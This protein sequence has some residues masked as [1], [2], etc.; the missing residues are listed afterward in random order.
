M[1]RASAVCE[2]AGFPAVSLIC[3]GF[4]RQASATSVGLGMPNL[5][6][7]MVPGHIDV[8]SEA[9]LRK[10]ILG[11][12]TDLVIEGLVRE[13]EKAVAETPIPSRAPAT[14]CKDR[15][16]AGSGRR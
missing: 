2:L 11:V 7:A 12:T 9:E 3:E 16:L 4:M 10:N 1:L 13:V 15:G 6:R 5:T 8:Q 14:P